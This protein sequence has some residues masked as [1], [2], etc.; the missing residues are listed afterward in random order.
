ML[1]RIGLGFIEKDQPAGVYDCGPRA[2]CGAFGLEPR[3]IEFRRARSCFLNTN[4]NRWRAGRTLDRWT[5]A[6]GGRPPVVLPGEFV[7]GAVWPFGDDALQEVAIDRRG[8]APRL[9]QGIERAQA[10]L[11][12]QPALQSGD[13]GLE[14]RGDLFARLVARFIRTDGAR[15]QLDGTWI[16]HARSRS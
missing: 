8:P 13:P 1:L 14:A 6:V 16:R 2:D 15:M 10:P 12:T 5:R 4:P 11:A 9:R 7:R 3:T